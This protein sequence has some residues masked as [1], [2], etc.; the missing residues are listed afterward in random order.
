MVANPFNSFEVIPKT[1]DY[2]T[3]KQNQ[4]LIAPHLK[5]ALDAMKEPRENVIITSFG[6]AFTD[7]ELSQRFS[8]WCIQAGLKNCSAHGLRKAMARR[9]AENRA[10]NREMRSIT[11]H[12][13][14]AEL[15]VY[16]RAVDQKL[17]ADKTIQSL[18]DSYS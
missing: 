2:K 6:K 15:E 13:G 9:M 8:K 18:S 17:L 11:Q 4:I 12:S 7:K 10:T 3:G 14:D 16:T 1:T 5:A